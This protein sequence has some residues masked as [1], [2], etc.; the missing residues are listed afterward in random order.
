MS[1]KEIF[2]NAVRIAYDKGYMDDDETEAFI[3]WDND[4]SEEEL[5][6]IRDKIHEERQKAF[7][8][9]FGESFY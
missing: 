5:I 1:W 6:A 2:A 9:L 7:Q 3:G 4:Y 8:E